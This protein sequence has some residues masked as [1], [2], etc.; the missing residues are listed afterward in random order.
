MKGPEYLYVDMLFWVS[1]M[2]LLTLRNFFL[3]KADAVASPPVERLGG[4][5][6]IHSFFR[7]FFMICLEDLCVGLTCVASSSDFFEQFPP[8]FFV[9]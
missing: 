1:N 8:V 7:N 2:N 4:L 3:G 5:E 9:S 6:E